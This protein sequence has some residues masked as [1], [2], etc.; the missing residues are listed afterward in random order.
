MKNFLVFLLIVMSMG[1]I[2]FGQTDDLGAQIAAA[3][4][5]LGARP[6]DIQLATSGTISEGKVSI[7]AG[8]NLVCKTGTKIFLKAGSYIYQNSYTS[9]KNCIIEAT[10][11]PILGEVQSLNTNHVELDSVTFVGGGYLVYWVGVTNFIITDNQVLNITAVVPTTNVVLSGFY[12]DKCSH[13]QVNNLTAGNFVFP[14]GVNSQHVSTSSI[15]PCS[16]CSSTGIFV[17]NRSSY[18][19]IN[20]PTILDV[21]ASYVLSG[22]GVIVIAGSTQVTVNGGIITGNA[23]MDGILSQ[24]Y[25]SNIRSSYLNITGLYSSYN[26]GEGRNVNAPLGL[27]DGLDLINTRHVSVSHCILD[28][29]GSLKDGQPGIWL[30]V[31]DDVLVADSDISDSSQ[32]GIA[33]AGSPHVR[34]LR[35]TINRNQATGV[36]TEYQGGTATNVG[37]AVTFV[38]GFSGGFGV[39][40]APGT[41]FTLDGAIYPIASVTDSTHLTLATSPADHSTPVAWGVETTQN[42]TNTVIDDNG[43]GKFGGQIQVGISWADGTSGI[44]SG[45]TATDTGAGT[46]LYGLEL[47]NTATA[48]LYN[49][50]FAGNVIGGI[51]GSSQIVSPSSLS[52][53][54]QTVGT[55]STPQTVTL[56]AGAIVV[57]NL[58]IQVSGDF[59]QSNN[60]GTGLA[61]FATC[62]IQVTFTPK[63]VGTR[64]GTLT[65][66][67]GAPNSPQTVSLTGI[68]VS[69]GSVSPPSLSFP[70][71]G[72]GTTSPAQ[73]VTLAAGLV[74][75]QNLL[76][77][78]SRNYSQ[79][80]NCGTALAASATCQINVTFAPT[81]VGTLDGTLTITDSS[82]NSPQMVLLTGSGVSYGLG[83]RVASSG[84]NFT[85]ITAGTTAKYLLSLGGKG[86]S[87]TASL[88]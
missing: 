88:T 51:F 22:A 38:S 20:N 26:G 47:Q 68:G 65:I 4:A 3:D 42:I 21:D 64:N 70:N 16:Q 71:Q 18:V 58:V 57:Q 49:D 72:L 14:T 17:L 8:H 82:S 75:I 34:L 56:T 86:V 10:S 27:G 37:P 44:I 9:I 87:G 79:T 43:Q 48:T 54:G 19:T 81:I 30:F 6:G 25:S 50:N 69:G 5:A 2:A 83:L 13:G 29:N 77:Q 12:L 24:S 62:Q 85:V 74:A 59:A 7:S 61:A 60:C 78:V 33:A 63:G 28:G 1:C 32:A 15:G 53:P 55:T 66:T 45:V 36:F 76:I 41:P 67:D 52:F 11:T 80:N 40:W 46:Q 39:A 73:T 31:D 35:D 84:S 23:N